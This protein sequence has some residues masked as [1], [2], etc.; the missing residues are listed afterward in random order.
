[1]VIVIKNI[2]MHKVVHCFSPLISNGVGWLGTKANLY[3]L[4]GESEIRAA[5]AAPILI[6]VTNA[7]HR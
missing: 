3:W 1:M 7:F 5:A 6:E 4:G 2:K